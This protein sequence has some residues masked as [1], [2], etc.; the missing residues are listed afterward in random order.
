MTKKLRL[1]ALFLA[2]SSAVVPGTCAYAQDARGAEASE[3]GAGDIIVTARKREESLQDVPLSIAAFSDEEL[4]RQQIE[5]L[6]D[7]AAKTP[8]FSFESYASSALETPVI[9]GQAQSFLTNPVQNVATF[10][11]GLYLQRGYMI[12]P[13]MVDMERIE[14]LKGPQSA[15]YG[16]NAFSGAISYI[17]KKPTND[18]D[19]KISGTVGSDERYDLASALG[20]PIVRDVLSFRVGAALTKFDGSWTNGHPLADVN[21]AGPSTQGNV[22]GYDN[23]SINAGLVFTPFDRLRIEASYYRT[24]IEEEAPA[25][26]LLLGQR[27]IGQL[28]FSLFNDLNCSPTV[29]FGVLGNNLWCGA[30]PNKPEDI[31]GAGTNRTGTE[32]VIDPR[33][34]GQSGVNEIYRGSAQFDITEDLNI[35]YQFGRVES[36]VYSA[37]TSARDVIAG[38]PVGAVFGLG[39]GRVPFDNQPN[40]GLFADSHEIRMQYDGDA[41]SVLGGALFYDSTDYFVNRIYYLLPLGTAPVS[42]QRLFSP[43]NFTILDNKTFATYASVAY[44]TG[45]WEFSAEVRYNNEKIKRFTTPDPVNGG[46]QFY[47]QLPNIPANPDLRPGKY[48]FWTPRF[49]VK[50]SPSDNSQIYVSAARGAKAGGFNRVTRDPAFQVYQPE[51]NWTYELG[52]KNRFLDGKLSVDAAVFHIDW[53]SLQITGREPTALAT[54]AAIITNLAGAKTWGVEGLVAYRPVPGLELAAAFSHVSPKLNKGTIYLE[55]VAGN[56]CD[57]VVCPSNGDVGG[58]Y[59]PRTPRTQY[60]VSADWQAPLTGNVDY[61][62]RADTTYQSKQYDSFLNLGWVSSRQLVNGSLGIE[63]ENF[64]VQLWAK[65]LFDKKYASSSLFGGSFIY[66]P[67]FGERRTFGLTASY[68]Y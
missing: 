39:S 64:R 20:G 45:P 28:R 24:E 29:Q 9:R 14:V 51:F 57:N 6:A 68:T 30:L 18:W 37:R 65:N 66:A 25:Q 19:V 31:P 52:T 13:G 56:W 62:V 43:A 4:E 67:V 42:L 35:F 10:V 16:Q 32:P 12:D 50:Y 63:A 23:W 26:Y 17:T 59:L 47:N 11:D 54:D 58:N 22:G 48:E 44:E 2:T 55:A 8:G 5:G 53:T 60:T 61:F 46:A 41:W 36:R 40:G 7:V 34:F 33:S 21:V 38:L 15:L 27:A 3:A 49:S 1:V